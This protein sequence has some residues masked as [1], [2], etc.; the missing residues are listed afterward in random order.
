MDRPLYTG[1]E[2]RPIRFTHERLPE[3]AVSFIHRPHPNCQL[4]RKPFP[5][6]RTL[7][8]AFIDH[9]ASMDLDPRPDLTHPFVD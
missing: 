7:A 8:D 1:P 2:D 6:P 9:R 5:Q 4:D 3:T